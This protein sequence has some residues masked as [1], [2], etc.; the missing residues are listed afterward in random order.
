MTELD[1][2]AALALTSLMK[3]KP[4]PKYFFFDL[5]PNVTK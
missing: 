2:L 4:S 1:G 3:K 5:K